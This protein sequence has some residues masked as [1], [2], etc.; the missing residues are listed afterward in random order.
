MKGGVFT[1]ERLKARKQNGHRTK[2]T[3]KK[4][5]RELGNRCDWK[6]SSGTSPWCSDLA[7]RVPE[8]STNSKD[9]QDPNGR[10]QLVLGT[11]TFSNLGFQN[12]SFARPTPRG[13]DSL[14]A[15]L[16]LGNAEKEEV[17]LR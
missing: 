2:Y 9:F 1:S 14:D 10:D 6:R 11:Q 4:S 15:K 8:F 3:K 7:P 17:E 16:E 5:P 12:W 13:S